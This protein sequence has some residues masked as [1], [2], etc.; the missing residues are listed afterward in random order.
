[1]ARR[2]EVLGA[3]WVFSIENDHPV[4]RRHDL[5]GGRGEEVGGRVRVVGWCV[6]ERGPIA[7]SLTTHPPPRTP[8]PPSLPPYPPK[9]PQKE[10]FWGVPRKGVKNTKNDDFDILCPLPAILF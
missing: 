2:A 10:G 3:G 4:I 7:P 6:R 9:N 5:S 1:M 8:L